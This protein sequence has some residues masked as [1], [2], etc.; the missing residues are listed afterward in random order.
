MR[1]LLATLF[2]VAALGL[3]AVGLWLL[4]PV[5]AIGVASAGAG[6]LLAPERSR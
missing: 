6:W 5:L 1:N 3:I 4:E 2:Q